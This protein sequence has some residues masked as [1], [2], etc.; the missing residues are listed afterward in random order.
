MS[1]NNNLS[2]T[3]KD[4]ESILGFVIDH[5]IK[6]KINEFDL[7][8]ELLSEQE[9]DQ[10]ILKCIYFLINDNVEVGKH[11]HNVW[12]FGWKENLDN[13]KINHDFDD[14]IPKYFN[15]SN[16]IRWNQKFIKSKNDFFDYKITSLMIDSIFCHFVK[17]KFDNLYEFGCGTGYNLLRFCNY[18]TNINLIGLDWVES[19]QNIIK[20]INKV[21][22]SKKIIGKNFNYFDIDKSIEI[23][24]NSVILTCASLEQIGSDFKDIVDF[25]I[26]KKPELCINFENEIDFLDHNDL[27]DGIS[28]SLSKK[29]N[30]L[31]GFLKY[32]TKLE[33]KGI[34][35]IIY[36][37]R[38][39]FG[40]MLHEGY[41][42]IIWRVK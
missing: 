24:K 42:V 21:F 8:F 38:L 33:N 4:L 20:E 25:W 6:E 14:L 32:L 19:S 27:I 1:M 30:Y 31:N 5:N 16:I 15:K 3:H 7:S 37:K 2:I 39:F 40:T 13:F 26:S 17:N 29:R 11:R 36:Q 23:E 34:I 10:I 12:E 35:D 18:D 41:P 22:P 9:R 28:I